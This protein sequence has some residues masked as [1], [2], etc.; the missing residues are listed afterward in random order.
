MSQ[1]IT[2]NTYIDILLCFIIIFYDNNKIVVVVESCLMLVAIIRKKQCQMSVNIEILDGTWLLCI[3]FSR[4]CNLHLTGTFSV[5]L[6]KKTVIAF[7]FQ[8]IRFFPH[9][10]YF[11]VENEIMCVIHTFFYKVKYGV[12]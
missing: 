7:I 12:K 11:S 8:T 10:F 1:T 4:I 5:Q 2:I 3:I 6:Q 9:V